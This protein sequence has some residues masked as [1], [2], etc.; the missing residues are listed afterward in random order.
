MCDLE[1]AQICVRAALTGHF[2]LSTLHTN[3]AS[4]AITRLMDLGI[5]SYL[6]TPS[7]SMVIAQRLAR[8]LCA[9]CKEPMEPN[10]ELLG[11][12]KFK[13][14]LIYKAAGCDGCNHTGYRGRLVITEAML[15]DDTMRELITKKASYSQV[16]DAARKGGM[17][18]LFED[19]LKKV[20]AG[21]TSLDEIL[22]VT[23]L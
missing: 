21:L 1:T 7:L 2:V 20:E 19:G 8:R 9:K 14:D 5:E 18:T 12:I 4:A 15:I 3:D 11:G 23:A 22:S 6:L 10:A 13:S 16:L 17:D